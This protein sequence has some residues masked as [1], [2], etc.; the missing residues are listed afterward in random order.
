MSVKYTYANT[1]SQTGKCMV[2]THF[3]AVRCWR[4]A[5]YQESVWLSLISTTPP[6]PEGQINTLS[7]SNIST[8]LPYTSLIHYLRINSSLPNTSTSL[9]Y[10]SNSSLLNT[11]ASLLYTSTLHYKIHP[12]HYHTHQLLTT[13]HI[14]F[15]SI[16][17]CFTVSR[18][19]HPIST[20]PLGLSN[21]SFS[22]SQLLSL[23]HHLWF[24]Q[25]YQGQR[26]KQIQTLLPSFT[27]FLYWFIFRLGGR[28]QGW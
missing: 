23:P 4:W 5:A 22:L 25:P 2:V 13:E 15:T 26:C 7:R 6:V 28:G 12:L 3:A 10:T 24:P 20:T 1:P 9:P 27:S 19:P 11:S 17:I 16:D 8:S 18:S 14:C 21:T